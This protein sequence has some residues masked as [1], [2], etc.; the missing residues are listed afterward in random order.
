MKFLHV[1]PIE[2]QLK[3]VLNDKRKSLSPTTLSSPTSCLFETTDPDT[4]LVSELQ[5][6][7]ASEFKIPVE[8][9]RLIHWKGYPICSG[10]RVKFKTLRDAGLEDR[11]RLTLVR[12]PPTVASPIAPT[13]QNLC[14][15]P[16]RLQR[17]SLQIDDGKICLAT[18]ERFYEKPSIP[19]VAQLIYRCLPSAASSI[20]L[21]KNDTPN[22]Q[23]SLYRCISQ[24]LFHGEQSTAAIR[25]L[26]TNALTKRPEIFTPDILRTTVQ[27]Y[28][29]KIINPDSYGGYIELS[30]IAL[31]Y[32]VGLAA[33]HTRNHRLDVY[34]EDFERSK[35]RHYLIYDGVHYD[36][37]SGVDVITKREYRLFSAEDQSVLNQVKRLATTVS[38]A[39][40][41]PTGGSS[42]PPTIKTQMTSTRSSSASQPATTSN[43][44]ST[45]HGISAQPVTSA[46]Q[47]SSRQKVIYTLP[48]DQTQHS[49]SGQPVT[50]ARTTNPTLQTGTTYR[51]PSGSPTT[52]SQRVNQA[53]HFVSGKAPSQILQQNTSATPIQPASSAKALTILAPVTSTTQQAQTQ[54]NTAGQLNPPR[55]A[56]PSQQTSMPPQQ[57]VTSRP[58]SSTP[59]SVVSGRIA[60]SRKL[61]APRGLT[62]QNTATAPFVFSGQQKTQQVSPS[63]FT[64]SARLSGLTT[65]SDGDQMK[66]GVSPVVK[67]PQSD[68]VVPSSSSPKAQD[69]LQ[70][71]SYKNSSKQSLPAS[72]SKRAVTHPPK[73]AVV[74]C[75]RPI[76]TPEKSRLS[77]VGRA[78]PTASS[79]KPEP[80]PTISQ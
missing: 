30:L 2:M 9:V 10:A 78:T 4:S 52:P 25:W 61:G 77:A 15:P 26:C 28:G 67:A 18:E 64:K 5:K 1:K 47:T 66:G 71:P 22:D 73:A 23:N 62:A 40:S 51:I 24:L 21:Q 44:V 50:T 32:S 43:V 31:E 36:W 45:Q 49:T 46:T 79:K 35:G 75:V 6:Y 59:Q 65:Q 60:S 27:D 69:I 68:V 13:V 38:K 80:L 3:I 29:K 42:E 8:S 16:V 56:T 74:G 37:V 63:Q 48:S 7:C 76:D 57:T 12:L 34:G 33:W 39:S 53:Q 70:P 17:R 14:G 20:I 58:D 55:T 54:E 11:D 19:A 72:V 41:T